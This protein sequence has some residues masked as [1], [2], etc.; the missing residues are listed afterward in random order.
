MCP[1]TEPALLRRDQK[2]AIYMQDALTIDAGKMGFGVL[3]YSP[4]PVACVIDSNYA[5]HDVREVIVTPRSAP[6]VATIEEAR[7]LG[8]DALVLGIAPPGGLI[9]PSWLPVIDRAVELGMSIVNGLHDL[10]APRY[11]GLSEGQFIWDIRVEPTGLS[12]G[13][14]AAR[15]LSN[16]RALLI[17]TDMAIGK[18]TAGLEIHRLALDRGIRSAFVATGQIGITLTGRGVPLDA[19]RVD[20]ASGA[21]ERE[22]LAEPEAE[23][24]LIEGQGALCHP[25]SSANLPLLR[26]SCPTHL[27]LCH[28]AGQTHL[29]RDTSVAIPPLAPYIRLYED[30]AEAVGTFPRPRTSCV[31]LNTAHLSEADAA[32]AVEELE[33]ELGLPTSDPVRHGPEKLLDALMGV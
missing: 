22:V 28:R 5:G 30:L 10:L 25:A 32:R 6:V 7:V 4:N 8:A 11:L 9:P 2:L 21:I 24:V 3:R 27:V 1:D 15:H 19:I 23:L 29:R 33:A 12:T 20:Y 31:A 17:G 16:R 18:M 26:G 13:T 14:G